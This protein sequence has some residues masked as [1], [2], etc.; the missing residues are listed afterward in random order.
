MPENLEDHFKQTGKKVMGW[1][2]PVPE[3][4]EVRA[5]DES[6]HTMVVAPIN[7]HQEPEVR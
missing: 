5:C 2:E 7:R 1:N 6:T 4:Y 3:G